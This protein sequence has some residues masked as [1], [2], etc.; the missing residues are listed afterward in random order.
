MEPSDT[1]QDSWADGR[2][3][4]KK[5]CARDEDAWILLLTRLSLIAIGYVT[6]TFSSDENVVTAEDAEDLAS[7][8]ALSL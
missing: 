4:L 3:T 7:K 6:R 1:S 5:L 2:I 8:L